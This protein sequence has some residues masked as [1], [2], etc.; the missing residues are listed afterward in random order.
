MVL[1]RTPIFWD[2]TQHHQVISSHCF[3]EMLQ[4]SHPWCTTT[5]TKKRALIRK[6]IC[7][8]SWAGWYYFHLF[9]RYNNSTHPFLWGSW[10]QRSMI[11]YKFLHSGNHT[12]CTIA[13]LYHPLWTPQDWRW[14]TLYLIYSY[15]LLGFQHSN[16][17]SQKLCA[18]T[19]EFTIML[20]SHAICYSFG[21]Y[22]Y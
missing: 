4:T 7:S 10:D 6:D 16:F 13:S 22:I 8:Q 9:S 12:P 18:I 20:W 2:M 5:T 15:P 11:S 3:K 19:Y 1:L 21:V 17:L 14:E